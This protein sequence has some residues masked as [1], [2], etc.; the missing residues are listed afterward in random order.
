MTIPHVQLD[1]TLDTVGEGWALAQLPADL[2]RRVMDRLGD[3]CGA[4]IHDTDDDV[5]EFFVPAGTV[6][7]PQGVTVLDCLAWI[8]V[9][10][11]HRTEPSGRHWAR[12][13]VPAR[14]A[15]TARALAAAIRAEQGGAAR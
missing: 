4:V 11:D 12:W 8:L 14:R 2:G 7:W 1:L 3:E 10:A 5:L 15:T 6:H 13:R 9:P